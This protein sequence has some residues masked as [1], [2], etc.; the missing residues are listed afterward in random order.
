MGEIATSR[1]E[2]FFSIIVPTYNSEKTIRYTLDSIYDQDFDLSQLEILVIDGGS[3]DQT[4]SIAAEYD[5]VRILN[6]P[7]RL[8]EYA[9]A[10]GHRNAIGKYV[11]RMDS[12][13]EFTYSDQLMDKKV[14]LESHPDIRVLL[15]NGYQVGR[16]ELCGVSAAYMN[17]LG[18]PFSYFVYSIKGDRYQC[19]KTRVA[20]EDDSSVIF[21]F[22]EGDVYPL[23]DSTT[24]C[25]SL[26]YARERYP[27]EYDTI[28]F[29]C[30]TYER[31]I[32]DNGG[33]CG[34]LK[35]DYISHNCVSTLQVYFRKLRFRVVNNVFHKDESGFSSHETGNYLP[36]MIGFIIYCVLVPIP[37]ID[38][39]RLVIKFKDASFGLHFVYVYWVCLE[40]TISYIMKILGKTRYN[41]SYG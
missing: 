35:R 1:E 34:L 36:R 12:D 21:Q 20:W 19:N 24:C 22:G 3:T 4:L 25:Y 10:I 16:D 27:D 23:A 5:R 26:T 8:P 28:G 33:R 7:Q 37:L 38:S 29:V 41:H 9:K 14:F 6:N 13:E 2:L 39:L 40:L 31:M 11:I 15:S 30:D 18:D 17:I 32:R